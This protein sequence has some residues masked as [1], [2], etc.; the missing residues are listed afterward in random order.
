MMHRRPLVYLAG[1]DVFYPSASM[2]LAR[3]A[4]AAAALGLDAIQPLADD[5]DDAVAIRRRCL[6][7]IE[8]S[9]AVLANLTP[10][11]GAHCDPGTAFECGFAQARSKPIFAYAT[12]SRLLSSRV[13]PRHESDGERDVAGMAIE[14]FGLFE[15]LMLPHLVDVATSADGLHPESLEAFWVAARRCAK[16][17]GG[18]AHSP[19]V[20]VSGDG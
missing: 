10:F 13:G 8:R 11:R 18:Q 16:A 6:E 14:G 4:E 17:L 12:E 3:K 15:N 1:P 19:A 5:L 7:G 9:D 2:L 20:G